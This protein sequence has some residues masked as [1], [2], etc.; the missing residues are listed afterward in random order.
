MQSTLDMKSSD[1]RPNGQPLS[2]FPHC[3]KTIIL[4]FYSTYLVIVDVVVYICLFRFT[5]DGL[6]DFTQV[7]LFT[8]SNPMARCITFTIVTFVSNTKLADNYF[9]FMLKKKSRRNIIFQ[10][11]L[12]P[13]HKNSLSVFRLSVFNQCTVTVHVQSH[14]SSTQKYTRRAWNSPRHAASTYHRGL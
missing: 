8:S 1:R 7:G 6:S 9:I 11:Y 14:A 2:R 5:I 13:N 12:N 4:S 3:Y 10:R